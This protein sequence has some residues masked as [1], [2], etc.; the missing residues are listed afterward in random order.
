MRRYTHTRKWKRQDYPSCVQIT[1]THA[2]LCIA[3]RSSQRRATSWELLLD[4]SALLCSTAVP[5][6]MSN[7]SSNPAI[8]SGATVNNGWQWCWCF[9][10]R[11]H[12]PTTRPCHERQVR[13]RNTTEYSENLQT[14][15]QRHTYDAHGRWMER[16]HILI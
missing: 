9:G 11:K 6:D 13:E 16:N 5:I 3:S 4:S 10:S 12:I 2:Y 15:L 14:V 7:G 8:Q 1:S